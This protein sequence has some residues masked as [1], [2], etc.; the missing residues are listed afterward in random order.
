[1]SAWVQI[2]WGRQNKKWGKNCKN[3]LKN[4]LDAIKSENRKKKGMSLDRKREKRER[5]RFNWTVGIKRQKG[6]SERF[7]LSKGIPK[8]FFF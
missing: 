1:M 2:H 6:K 5:F 3:P 4:N 8:K 7:F